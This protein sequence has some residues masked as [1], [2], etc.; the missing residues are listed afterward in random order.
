MPL[1][2]TAINIIQMKYNKYLITILTVAISVFFCSCKKDYG[3]LNSPTIE[4][5]LTNASKSDLNTLVSGTESGMRNSLGFYLDDVSIL[6][7][8]G[9]RF[10]DA[11]PRYV[12]DLL[13]ASD[14]T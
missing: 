3:N 14:A 9:Y 2:T 1:V 4:Q 12:L 7:R 6:G 13:G 10:S 5:F 11:E 8:E